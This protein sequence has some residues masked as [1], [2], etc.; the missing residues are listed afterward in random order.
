[1][2]DHRHV[3]DR[4]AAHGEGHDDTKVTAS[5]TDAPEEVGADVLAA[6]YQL[7]VGSANGGPDEVVNNPAVL[8][9]KVTG[10]PQG[11]K[12]RSLRCRDQ[13]Q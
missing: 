4:M 12:V 1:V 6:F 9:R 7:S 3:G 5:T 11:W 2:L 10:A 8:A 13:C